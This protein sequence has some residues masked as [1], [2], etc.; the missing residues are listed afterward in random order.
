[1]LMIAGTG[2]DSWLALVSWCLLVPGFLGIPELFFHHVVLVHLI[3]SFLFGSILGWRTWS[4]PAWAGVKLYL[5]GTLRR[6][7]QNLPRPH[8]SRL[9]QIL[10]IH[11][12]P[13]SRRWRGGQNRV[14]TLRSAGSPGRKFP[15]AADYSES[16][17]DSRGKQ[18]WAI[19]CSFLLA[20]RCHF[21]VSPGS[22]VGPLVCLPSGI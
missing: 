14:S 15:W 8:Q 9:W 10:R 2:R 17:V 13:L 16:P 20:L 18:L 22:A 7:H 6:A 19:H 21:L 11:R 3:P 12:V 1:M 4:P 5:D